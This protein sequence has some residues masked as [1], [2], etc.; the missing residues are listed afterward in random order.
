M[1]IQREFFG[2]RSDGVKLYRT[3]SDDG[4]VIRQNETGVLLDEA[5]DVENAAY[6]YSETGEDVGKHTEEKNDAN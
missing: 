3:F 6:T 1:A 4:K 2:E 5:V